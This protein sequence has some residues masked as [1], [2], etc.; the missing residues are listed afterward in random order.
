M[1]P[2]GAIVRGLS[3]AVLEHAAVGLVGAERVRRGAGPGAGLRAGGAVPG[4]EGYALAVLEEV[5][6]LGAPV[7]HAQPHRPVVRGERRAQ[8]A[9]ERLH[10]PTVSW[11]S[12]AP[13]P[14]HA[15]RLR[16]RLSLEV[17]REQ[18][19]LV[20]KTRPL[21]AAC[22]RDGAGPSG[23][24]VSA[25]GAGRGGDQSHPEPVTEP[26]GGVARTWGRDRR[27]RGTAGAGS[28]H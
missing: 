28:A 22:G 27:G 21:Q 14:R 23:G 26:P 7:V 17:A 16:R 1:V 12:Q 3:H 11:L 19:A 25:S 5:Q 4:E 10:L 24:G 18:E 9:G 15:P 13:A 2:P 6:A 20:S 8:V